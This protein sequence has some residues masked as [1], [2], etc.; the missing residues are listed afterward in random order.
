MAIQRNIVPTHQD[1]FA[2]E[3]NTRPP[4]ALKSGTCRPSVSFARETIL[5]ITK[6]VKHTK[7]FSSYVNT[8][9][10]KIVTIQ[11]IMF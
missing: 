2:V 6:V 5:P 10:S 4:I 11:I 1:V 7:T 3:K 9:Q 8:P